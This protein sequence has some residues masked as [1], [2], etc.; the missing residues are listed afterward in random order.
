MR[1]YTP[2]QHQNKNCAARGP[3]MDSG[4]LPAQRQPIAKGEPPFP[5][6]NADGSPWWCG[7]TREQLRERCAKLTDAKCWGEAGKR[8]SYGAGGEFA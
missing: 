4:R 5:L 2:R 1:N 7:L 6:W 8:N 3:A